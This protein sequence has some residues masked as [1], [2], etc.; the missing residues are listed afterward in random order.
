MGDFQIAKSLDNVLEKIV[1]DHTLPVASYG[2]L[3]GAVIEYP[4]TSPHRNGSI[5]T[6]SL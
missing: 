5:L 3:T 2:F 6:N 4:F 1:Y